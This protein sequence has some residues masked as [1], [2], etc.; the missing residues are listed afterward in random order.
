MHFVSVCTKLDSR[1]DIIF[2]LLINADEECL[3]GALVMVVLRFALV[4]GWQINII[5]FPCVVGHW[6]CEFTYLSC[7]C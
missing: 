5:P 7:W 3:N 2:H 6:F 1:A 4:V